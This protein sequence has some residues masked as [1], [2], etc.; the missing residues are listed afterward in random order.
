VSPVTPPEDPF[1]AWRKRGLNPRDLPAFFAEFEKE[2]PDFFRDFEREFARMSGVM[3][4]VMEDAMKHASSPRRGEPFVYGFSMRVG[5]D[6]VPHLTPFGSAINQ[7]PITPEGGEIDATAL[8]AAREPLSDVIE[9]DDEITV[10]VELPGAE[11]QDLQ[12]HV[13]EDLVTVKAEKGRRY[14][15]RIK[16]P[17]LVEPSS[18]KATFKNSILDLV[19]RKKPSQTAGAKVHIE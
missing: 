6:G 13:A 12:L 19:L 17:A 18:A 16:L 2:F 1:D 14:A 9:S 3:E 10:T 5:S 4:R 7:T 11:K 15:A 8:P